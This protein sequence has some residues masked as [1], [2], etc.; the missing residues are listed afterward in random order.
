MT[1]RRQADQEF[2][3]ATKGKTQEQVGEA[4]EQR[5]N[6]YH[7]AIR[8]LEKAKIALPGDEDILGALGGINT[9]NDG[10][11]ITTDALMPTDIYHW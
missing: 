6:K 8:L 10:A 5:N 4:I 11:Y 1:L 3:V 9:E 2:E 7:K